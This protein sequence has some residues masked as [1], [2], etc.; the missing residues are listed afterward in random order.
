[1]AKNRRGV[2]KQEAEIIVALALRKLGIALTKST[3]KVRFSAEYAEE[4]NKWWRGVSL[5]IFGDKNW[6]DRCSIVFRQVLDYLNFS[7]RRSGG[8]ACCKPLCP[9]CEIRKVCEFLESVQYVNMET[10]L[11][12]GVVENGP[13]HIAYASIGGVELYSNA[14]LKYGLATWAALSKGLTDRLRN[15]VA[16]IRTKISADFS[17]LKKETP[18]RIRLQL[19]M[20]S[21]NSK[22]TVLAPNLITSSGP[23]VGYTLGS[24]LYEF[25]SYPDTLIFTTADDLKVLVESSRGLR[26]RESIGVLRR[27]NK[28]GNNDD[29]T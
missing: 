27:S 13:A 29:E 24:T 19:L 18:W 15:E 8:G 23:A 9:W 10:P 2:A 20:V 3:S 5:D 1:M 25:W 6:S 21:Q 11:G 4:I 16:G 22:Q 17:D 26:L 12:F 28:G 14:N 7:G